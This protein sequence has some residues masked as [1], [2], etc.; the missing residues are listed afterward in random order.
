VLSD[1]IETL[2]RVRGPTKRRRVMLHETV[3]GNGVLTVCSA[4]VSF[5]RGFLKTKQL[6]NELSVAKKLNQV[7]TR[8]NW[9]QYSSNDR[10]HRQLN[11]I[12]TSYVSR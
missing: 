7:Y 6:V 2:C 11:Y 4:N 5:L 9:L 1:V 8:F 3:S 12:P 10:T